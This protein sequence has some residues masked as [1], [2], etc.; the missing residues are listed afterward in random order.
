[1]NDKDI[2]KLCSDFVKSVDVPAFIIFGRKVGSQT[3]VTFSVDKKIA[4]KQFTEGVLS[5]L[6]QYL[7]KTK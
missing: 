5:S 1:M 7:G 2:E 6:L 3:K 4:P